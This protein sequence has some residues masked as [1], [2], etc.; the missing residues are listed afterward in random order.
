MTNLNTI[1]R[2]AADYIV[3][4][5]WIAGAMVASTG[6]VCLHGAIRECTPL[7]GDAEIVRT[8]ARFKGF[9][10]E[11]NDREATQDD[12]LIALQN[13]QVTDA[14]LCETFG[15][16]WEPFVALIRNV[17]IAIEQDS[18]HLFQ[19]YQDLFG[20]QWSDASHKAV[21]AGKLAGLNNWDYNIAGFSLFEPWEMY[22]SF[23]YATIGVLT[24]MSVRHLIGEHG[25][26]QDH[27]NTIIRPWV[28]VFGSIH[29]DDSL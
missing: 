18:T 2:L 9:H 26:E 21:N 27:Y 15:P 4:H 7:K 5:G 6:E 12:V 13:L 11:W 17:V 25:F 1:P 29:P 23:N 16:N 8:V 19:N 28:A 14:E 3:E 20:A 22:N 24:A 10:E